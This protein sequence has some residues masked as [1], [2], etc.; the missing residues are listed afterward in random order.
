MVPIRPTAFPTLDSMP[1]DTRRRAEYLK[2]TETRPTPESNKRVPAKLRTM[3]TTVATVFALL[4]AWLS[5]G[6]D[7][8]VG[9]SVSFDANDLFGSSTGRANSAPKI[10]AHETESESEK[11]EYR[12]GTRT[13]LPL[14]TVP[15]STHRP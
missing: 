2:T 12:S 10:N 14:L 13:R 1:I 11:R 4:G 6:N 5:A 15:T 9:I 3:Q 8:A 7:A